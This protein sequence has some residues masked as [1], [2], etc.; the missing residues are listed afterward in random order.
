MMCGTTYAHDFLF[1][2]VKLKTLS[3]YAIRHN[4]GTED[5]SKESKGHFFF[6]KIMSLLVEVDNDVYRT[7]R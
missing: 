3:A 7:V 6:K 4:N 1:C 5:L 2:E